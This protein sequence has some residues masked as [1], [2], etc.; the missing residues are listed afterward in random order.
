MRL[1]R[2]GRSRRSFS[3]GIRTPPI[4]KQTLFFPKKAAFSAFLCRSDVLSSFDFL[5]V[6]AKM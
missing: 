3:G 1:T 5:T 6:Y 4:S 2:N